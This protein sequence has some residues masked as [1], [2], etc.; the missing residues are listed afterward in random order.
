M[1]IK[2]IKPSDLQVWPLITHSHT[3]RVWACEINRRLVKGSHYASIL[4]T[5]HQRRLSVVG[6]GLQQKGSWDFS[7]SMSASIKV[8]HE[9]GEGRGWVHHK[10]LAMRAS[11]LDEPGCCPVTPWSGASATGFGAMDFLE[12]PIW[13]LQLLSPCTGCIVS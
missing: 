6:A 3:S 13:G 11:S 7:G 2:W 8:H 4:I 9:S 1:I 12:E 5:L 10:S